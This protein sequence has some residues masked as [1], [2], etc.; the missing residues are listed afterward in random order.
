MSN[1]IFPGSKKVAAASAAAT[2]STNVSTSTLVAQLI[3]N[4]G[5][6]HT[7][8]GVGSGTTGTVGGV[9]TQNGIQVGAGGTTEVSPISNDTSNA[10]T[11]VASIVPGGIPVSSQKANISLPPVN[12]KFGERIPIS[13]SNYGMS[14]IVR[15]NNISQI[16][17]DPPDRQQVVSS[18]NQ[19]A[20]QTII[21][22]GST[23]TPRANIRFGSGGGV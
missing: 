15:G 19:S 17:Q 1:I 5:T 18:I 3:K 16:I 22:G 2:T 8:G 23:T 21:H 4:T 20:N 7:T 14:N 12:I 9:G 10:M 6:W 13:Y 11:S